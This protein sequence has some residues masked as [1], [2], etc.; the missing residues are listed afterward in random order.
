VPRF[1]RFILILPLLLLL[2]ADEPTFAQ[3]EAEAKSAPMP[4]ALSLG[5]S[6]VF[7]PSNGSFPKVGA[8]MNEGENF[9]VVAWQEIEYGANGSNQIYISLAVHVEATEFWT[10]HS[11]VAGPYVFARQDAPSIMNLCVTKKGRIFIIVTRSTE[12]ADIYHSNDRGETF[13]SYSIPLTGESGRVSQSARVAAASAAAGGGGAATVVAAASSAELL[14]PS[15]F[16]ASDGTFLMF[17]SRGESDGITL[18]YARSEE[19][20]V[21]SPFVPFVNNADLRLNFLPVHAALGG[22][23][24]V[25]FQSFI[26]GTVNRPNF[27][28]YLSVSE[29]SGRSWSVPQRI[30]TFPGAAGEGNL[31]PEAN[32]PDYLGNERASLSLSKNP[33]GEDALFLVWERRSSSQNPD[34]QGVFLDKNG[35]PVGR[36]EKISSDT[37]ASSGNPESFFYQNTRYTVWFDNRTGYNS[38]YLGTRYQLAWEEREISR[39]S[40]LNGSG[41]GTP[42]A[43]FPRPLLIGNEFFLLWEEIAPNGGARGG[44]GVPAS[45]VFL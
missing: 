18:F 6:S 29:D 22:K 16:E 36:P 45:R 8:S 44:G 39:R 2:R 27:Q 33:V 13:A 19:G 10:M 3:D 42:E 43:L 31:P 26:A 7:S 5:N 1:S 4:A 38:I 34:I 25:V 15:M 40:A 23:D 32:S 30:T 41:A 12:L 9:G 20:S 21:W 11:R 24:F 14:V 17:V 28:L 35:I 37:S